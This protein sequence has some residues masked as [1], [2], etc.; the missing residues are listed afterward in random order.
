M[1]Q[2]AFLMMVH[3][4]PL[5][6]G[7]I[8][9]I[10]AASNHHFYAHIDSKFGDISAFKEA[11]KGI[12]NVHFITERESVHH[13]G[14]SHLYALIK[15]FKES[16]DSPN[17]YDYFHI[18]SGQD[19]PLR[20]NEQFDDFFEG[21][22]SS[23]MWVDHH[24]TKIQKFKYQYWSRAWHPN[25]TSTKWA[26][27]C[28]KL[29]LSVIPFIFYR[30][31]EIPNYS[32]GWDWFTWNRKVMNYVMS[33]FDQSPEFIKRFS[34]TVCPTE[35]IFHTI[36]NNKS[37]ELEID[38]WSPLR[39][40][41]WVPQR[42]LENYYLPYNLSEQDFERVIDSKAFFCR[43]VDENESSTLMDMIDCQRGSEYHIEDHHTII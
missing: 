8:I 41:S 23:F 42:K 40:V 28:N 37:E 29:H 33:Q 11:V 21:T 36:L 34:H 30:R 4:Q 17:N 20:S 38:T 6:F 9:K 16:M 7:R 1:K 13:C 39:Y 5:L 10:L 14:I 26:K 18:I 3:K 25:N 22:N 43:K 15:M 2:H 12:D 35:H 24:L 19:Y 27:I 31:R 32:G